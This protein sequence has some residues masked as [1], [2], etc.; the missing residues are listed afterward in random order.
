MPDYH[1]MYLKLIA[2]QAD[3]IDILRKAEEKLIQTHREAEELML[4]APETD[5]HLFNPGDGQD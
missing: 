2:A 1:A 4:S 3:A 5:I